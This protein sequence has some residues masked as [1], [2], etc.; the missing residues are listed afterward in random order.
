MKIKSVFSAQLLST[1][2]SESKNGNT[3]YNVTIFCPES[4]EAGQMNVNESIFNSLVPGR[5]YSFSAEWNDKYNT[6]RIIGADD[7]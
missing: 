4:G 3:Y 6:F 1:S 7:E 2:K 5:S